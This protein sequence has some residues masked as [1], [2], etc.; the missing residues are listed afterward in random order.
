MATSYLVLIE[1][2]G[3]QAFIFATNKLRE[4]V[5]ASQM[6]HLAGKEFVDTAVKTLSDAERGQVQ[7]IVSTSGKAILRVPSIEI[8]KA[9]IREVTRRALKEA[10]GLDVRGAISSPFDFD[11]SGTIHTTV[12]QVHE[13]HAELGS[14][15]PGPRERFL[16]LPVV[17]DC[18]TSGLPAM[19]M[20]NDGEKAI[21][22]SK[23]TDAKREAANAGWSRIRKD[24][25]SVTDEDD[26]RLRLAPGPD[27]LDKM[28]LNWLAVIHAD[29]NGFG[30]IFRKFQEYLPGGRSEYAN[31]IYTQKLQE[32]S[33]GLDKCTL[34]A[35]R[36]ALE[37]MA[38]SWSKVNQKREKEEK[39]LPVVPLILGGDD[40]TVVCDGRYAVQ[41]ARD[42][43]RAFESAAQQLVRDIGLRMQDIPSP[44]GACAGIAIVKPHY[45]FY[46]AYELAE[47]LLRSAKKLKAFG[48]ALDFHILYDASGSKLEA[49]R[50]KLN[51][52]R[53]ERDDG[54][55]GYHTKLVA[56]PYVVTPSSDAPRW[57]RIDD[58]A[59]RV[60]VLRQRKL[61]RGMLHEL[62]EGLFLGVNTA[63]ARLK[64]ARRRPD[65]ALD[66]LLHDEKLFFDDGDGHQITGFLDALDLAEFWETEDQP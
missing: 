57:R 28:D 21:S 39:Y 62:R 48:S 63:E 37:R 25:G 14:F 13:R 42:F 12:K 23:V 51:F 27:A 58:L 38:A 15:V 33:D 4:N 31:S 60:T 9:I 17:A 30:N 7:E 56:R 52:G 22:I 59:K 16:R 64:L 55:T 19:K 11:Q 49:I 5:G 65:N 46:A 43:L 34:A 20:A 32:F 29:G 54:T 24:V 1:T 66:G 61:P 18:A 50:D 26:R 53:V 45:P 41:L 36:T 47:E 35:F 6:T 44:L 40:L 2:A 10:P 8:G 3:N